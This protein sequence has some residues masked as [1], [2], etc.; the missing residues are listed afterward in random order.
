MYGLFTLAVA[1]ATALITPA[2]AAP[3]LVRPGGIKGIEITS[4][5]TINATTTHTDDKFV[6]DVADTSGQLTISMVNNFGSS[7][8]N[9]YITGLDTSGA[10]VM[11]NTDGAWYY[12][13]PAG[14]TTPVT[15]DSSAGV[16][17]PLGAA[18]STTTF[19]LP[20]YMSSGRVWVADG[21]LSFFAVAG[22]DGA[23]EL[24]EP[25]AAA[26]TD[27][28]AAVNWGFVE[29]TNT[30]DGGIYANISF[31]DFVGLV[32]GMVLALGDNTTQTVKGLPAGA[33]A[34]VCAAM[35]A[36]GA[37]DGSSWADMCVTDG[38]GNAL[39]VLA[40]N[41]YLSQDEAAQ[42]DYWTDYVSDVWTTYTST[43]LVIDTQAAAGN[44]SC[45]VVGDELTCDGDNRGYPQPTTADIWGCNSGPFAIDSGD[46]DVHRAVV[47]RL[48]AA[49]NRAELLVAGGAYEPSLGSASFY[50]TSPANH[51]SRIVHELELDGLGYAFSYDDVNA[52]GGNAAGVVS[53]VN[54]TSLQLV[55][56]GFSS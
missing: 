52:D 19:T 28:S 22:A 5:N 46:N 51:Y 42:A 21:E 13:D 6:S 3:I 34:G 24:V 35:Q 15:I 20:D 10:V 36:Q 12:P 9:A 30:A 37:E 25:S 40:P 53:G 31:V 47:P 49:F 2:L 50:T 14:S 17:L 26:A 38:E 56:G 4:L 16:A 8:M 32:I 55:I 43:P 54:P 41:L 48:C 45:T 7:S 27:P 11:L 39:R 44:V 23:S 18:G 29:L 1:A 33:V